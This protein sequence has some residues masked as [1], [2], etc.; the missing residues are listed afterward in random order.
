MTGRA[1]GQILHVGQQGI[2]AGLKPVELPGTLETKDLDA[3]GDLAAAP[4]VVCGGAHAPCDANP[5][6]VF[7]DQ[8]DGMV[9]SHGFDVDLRV[10]AAL[11]Q[12]EP[13]HGE[14]GGME[15]IVLAEAQ[16]VFVG[17]CHVRDQ[18]LRIE[19]EMVQR[20]TPELDAREAWV[21]HGLV[22]VRGDQGH[23]IGQQ[24]QAVSVQ[25]GGQGG[26]ARA[27][28]PTKSEGRAVDRNRTDMQW[29]QAALMQQHPQRRPQQ[30]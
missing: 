7:A 24:G 18:A 17:A 19:L 11:Q 23:V 10:R 5:I 4:E 3:V 29:Q 22:L 1:T 6:G 15:A 25:R 8:T 20:I 26:L 12:V 2:G 13:A 30:P 16:V 27:G 14:G 9:P 21:K 28:V